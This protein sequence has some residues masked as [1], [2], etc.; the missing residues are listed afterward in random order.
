[1]S[2]THHVVSLCHQAYE[3]MTRENDQLKREIKSMKSGEKENVHPAPTFLL[4]PVN[5]NESPCGLQSE[6][7]ACADSPHK[8][9]PAL[10]AFSTPVRPDVRM[11][12]VHASKN[13]I[14]EFKEWL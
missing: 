9:P 13:P 1:M 14:T 6:A 12:R 5:G 11:R 2:L 7:S 10:P 3:E 4:S 8:L